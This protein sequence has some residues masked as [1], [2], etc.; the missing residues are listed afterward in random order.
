[1]S[2]LPD[3]NTGYTTADEIM[4]MVA[5]D[6]KNK[7]LDRDDI[8]EWCAECERD[9]VYD[10]DQMVYYKGIGL[11]VKNDRTILPCNIFRLLEAKRTRN[12][13]RITYRRNGRFLIFGTHSELGA[14]YIDY[15]GLPVDENGVPYILEGHEQAC[16]AYVVYKL[17]LG[18][19]LAQKITLNAW[20]EIKQ[21]MI[22][23]VRACG[24]DFRHYSSEYF[25]SLR[26]IQFDMVPKLYGVKLIG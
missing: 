7:V 2:T 25:D 24:Q 17:Y 11:A 14:V 10:I 6:H 13:T 5:R 16:A 18:D 23:K 21:D 15:V 4:A 3:N 19:F 8:I 1:M 12:G 20:A 26:K 9:F 22:N